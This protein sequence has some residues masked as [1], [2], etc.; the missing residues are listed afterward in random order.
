M[1]HDL[2]VNLE[3]YFRHINTFSNAML[4]IILLPGNSI[5]ILLQIIP[6]FNQ[7]QPHSYN[8]QNI[9]SNTTPLH[10]GSHKAAKMR[11]LV[12]IF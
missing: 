7:K 1:C 10:D 5:Q 9:Q 12:R 4:C 2:D 6:K 11:S 8:W 3:T